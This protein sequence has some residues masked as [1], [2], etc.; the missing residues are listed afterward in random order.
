VSFIYFFIS[1]ANFGLGQLAE[2]TRGE[3]KA[4]A[5]SVHTD[6]ANLL[7]KLKTPIH[8]LSPLER[9]TSKLTR[10]QILE[11]T[12]TIQDL[13]AKGLRLAT[14]SFQPNHHLRKP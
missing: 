5:D 9:T 7:T 3:T 10:T 14:C 11:S 6:L 4:K 2:E 1:Y 12:D 13:L 8:T